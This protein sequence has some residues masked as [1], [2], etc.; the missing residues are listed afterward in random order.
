[1][2]YRSMERA[3][4]Q[5]CNSNPGTGSYQLCN[6]SSLSQ[7]PHFKADSLIMGL[8]RELNWINVSRIALDTEKGAQKMSPPLPFLSVLWRW[9]GPYSSF[10][11]WSKRGPIRLMLRNSIFLR[12]S[13][14]S[15]LAG[16]LHENG[17]Q[18]YW[19]VKWKDRWLIKTD[20]LGNGWLTDEFC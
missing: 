2:K 17:S 19:T 3:W 1:M 10:P 16:Q 13:L 4:R 5:A 6:L 20:D 7:F 8:L 11:H 15:K 14:L 18:R 12:T 9:L